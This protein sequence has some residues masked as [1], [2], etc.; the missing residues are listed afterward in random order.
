MITFTPK[1][2]EARRQFFLEEGFP[3]KHVEI[4]G[5]EIDYFEIPQDRNPALPHF[6]LRMTNKPGEP[7][8]LGLADS[9]KPEHQ[10]LV[11][12]YEFHRFCVLDANA[13][14]GCQ[15]ALEVELEEVDKRFNGQ[16]R[17]EYLEMRRD[18]FEVLRPFCEQFPDHY[19]PEDLNQ[20]QA[21]YQRL[22]E[23][24]SE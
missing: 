23:L 11:A 15:R 5:Q 1:Q 20:F 10:P 18:F 8:L 3:V 17:V 6:A 13:E 12:L 21:N 22:D 24:L 4:G 7:Y 9:I 14:N 16:E 19:S 2:I